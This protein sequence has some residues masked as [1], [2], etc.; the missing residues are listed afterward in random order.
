MN[1]FLSAF[2]RVVLLGAGTA[3]TFLPR[4]LEMRLGRV[5][6]R[7]LLAI[8]FKRYKIAQE[9]MARCLPELSDEERR[10]LLVENYRHYGILA[11]ELL[12]YFSPFR[13]HFSDYARRIAVLEGYENWQAANAR[14]KGVMCISLH[15]ANWELMLALAA[16]RGI[17]STLVTRH[18]KPE[19]LHKR[20]EAERLAYG[21]RCVYAP[22]TLLVVLRA[23]RHG[24]SVGIAMDQYMHPPAGIPVK[25]FGVEVDTLTAPTT[26]ALRTGAALL[27]VT[28]KREPDGRVR[29]IMFPE[30]K[31]GPEQDLALATAPLIRVIEGMIRD[32]PSQWLWVHR[33]F[34]NLRQAS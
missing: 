29:I 30:I 13:G 11:L 18:L 34:K 32:N 24:E 26:L 16:L 20:L 7:F 27:P 8:D 17:P 14:G 25:F 4:F 19:W 22:N 33:R 31:P 10:R 23:L 1:S 9:N 2:L 15:M 5:L 28:Q 12:H 3:V 21:C 6:G